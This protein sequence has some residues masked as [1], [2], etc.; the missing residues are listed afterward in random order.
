MNETL[1]LMVR[2]EH[3]DHCSCKP[4]A[5]AVGQ[6]PRSVSYEYCR[7][8]LQKRWRMTCRHGERASAPAAA[9]LGEHWREVTSFDSVQAILIGNRQRD[10]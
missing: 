2:I 3:G 5:L 8:V 4:L 10:D 7:W 6:D 9:G 1:R